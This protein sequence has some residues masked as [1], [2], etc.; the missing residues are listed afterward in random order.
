MP[1]PVEGGRPWTAAQI[2]Q[3]DKEIGSLMRLAALRGAEVGFIATDT[4]RGTV[5][6]SRD[7]DD[8]FMPASNFKLL[9][10]STALERLGLN[11][12]Y[13]T[14][15]LADT[16]P[17]GSVENGN[18]YLHGGG[19]SLLSAQDLDAA[20]QAVAAA[21]VTRVSG[22]VVA[23]DSHFDE[24]RLGFGWSWDDLPYYYAPV[25]TALE[26]EDGVV[27]IHMTPGAT[28]GAPV[29]L[30]VEPQSTTFT[31]D[32]QLVTGAAGS[33]DTSDIIRPWNEPTTIVLT[34]SY[35]LG[36][37]ESGDLRPSVPDPQ[38]Y[39]ADVFT[40]ALAAHG[41]HVEGA[42]KIG[43]APA[44]AVTLWSHNSLP[45]PELLQ[46]FWY[47]SDN[48]MGEL[49][50]KQLGVLGAGEPG[51]DEHGADVEREFLQSIH[52]DPN[53]VSISDGSGLSQYDRI[54]PRDLLTILQYD[55]NAPYR[56]VV[57][58]AL[59]FAGVR[60]TL[61]HAY[62]G[63]PAEHHVWAKTGSI[64]HVRTISGFIQTATHG[65]VTFSLMINQWMGEDH[66][67][68]PAALA[69]ARGAI[70]SAIVVK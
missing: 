18:L 7:A 43:K 67:D 49:L 12:S 38:S 19:D 22:S 64:S 58:D 50:L 48:L 33:K 32:N 23:D 17:Q 11:F 27:H 69:R 51:T 35:P 30:S 37:K 29:T 70:L 68:G 1:R 57:I 56:D 31:I 47:P 16:Q 66:P 52:L 5:L 59:P 15:V 34:G 13:V 25:V 36:A 55:W 10:G 40:Q 26:L 65:V 45:M 9:V 21:G 14:T 62:V 53:T 61:E 44:Q 54:T 46:R 4:Q 20:A 63:T 6:Y 60:G 42:I 2:H 41:V 3:L 28:V 24:Q 8:E 39:A